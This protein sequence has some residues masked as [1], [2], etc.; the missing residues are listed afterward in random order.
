MSSHSHSDSPAK[1]LDLT[2]WSK[3]PNLLMIVGGVLAAVGFA[4]PQFR[5]QFGYSWLLA[6]MFFLSI[7][8][9]SLFILLLHHLFD[10]MWIVPIRRFVEHLAALLFPWLA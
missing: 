9:G 2:K 8:L 5:E 3:V 7:G 4:V 1:P 6:F 10:A